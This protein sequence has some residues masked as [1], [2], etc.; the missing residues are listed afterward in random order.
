MNWAAII[1]LA[2]MVFFLIVEAACPI[3]LVS[4]WFA[5]A[6]L[7]AIIVSLLGGQIWLQVVVFL[8]VSGALL[9]ALW[10]LVK[11]YMKP[12]VVATN[13]DSLVGQ[14]AHVTQDIDNVD[15]VG[16]AKVNGLEW[17]ARSTDGEPIPKGV[18]VRID[19]VEGAKLMVSLAEGS[20]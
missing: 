15:A 14:L 3:H 19:R 13:V 9:L 17:S 16:Q 6:S 8:A 10:P 20:K 18:L 12:K 1:W 11:K 4:V 7:I 2:M 5:L